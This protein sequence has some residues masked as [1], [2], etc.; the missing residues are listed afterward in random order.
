MEKDLG[1]LTNEMTLKKYLF[2]RVDLK[3]LFKD[4]SI[5]DYNAMQSIL[6]INQKKEESEKIYLRDLADELKIPISTASKMIGELQ[7]NGMVRWKHD[8]KG[9]KGTYIIITEKGEEV[10][11]KQHEVL[12]MFYG[13]VIERFGKDDF[14]KMLEMISR[15]ENVMLEEIDKFK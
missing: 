5:L 9:E 8:G 13:E 2:E 10:V 3:S 1:V 12:M 14:L 15:L 6:G 11:K 4:I 7:D